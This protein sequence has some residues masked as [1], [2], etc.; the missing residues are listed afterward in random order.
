[1]TF[2]FGANAEPQ[3]TDSDIYA[4]MCGMQP[5]TLDDERDEQDWLN[6]RRHHF[7]LPPGRY[8]RSSQRPQD[9]V[10]APGP[11]PCRGRALPLLHPW[12]HA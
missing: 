3:E 1:M 10:L 12:E 6:E 8:A 4:R 9:G 7:D 2:F 5:L 11:S